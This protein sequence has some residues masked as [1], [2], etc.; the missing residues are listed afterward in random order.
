MLA[1][2]FSE[3]ISLGAVL[4]FIGILTSPE[5]MF[6][7]PIVRDFA[8][9]LGISSPEQLVLPI[10]I[11]FATAAIVAGAIRLLMLWVSQRLAFAMGTD[12][13]LQIY[14]RTLYQPYKVHVARNSSEVI[15]GITT[16]TWTV[17]EIIQS[18]LTVVSSVAI[19]VCLTIVLFAV[20]PLVMSLATT[21]LGVCY[22]LIAFACKRKVKFNGGVIAT[23]STQIVKA[24]QEGLGG[25]RDVLLS[26]SQEVYSETYRRADDRLRRAHGNN[27]FMS[28]GPRFA[29]EAI[30]MA[31]IAGLAYAMSLQ[32]GSVSTALPV[33]ATLALGA[34]RLLPIIQLLYNSW[35]SIAGAGKSLE[36]ALEFLDQP[37]SP[38]ISSFSVEPLEFRKCIDLVGV[39]FRYLEDGSWI[40]KDLDLK[41]LKGCRV[42]FVGSTGSGKSTLLDI[43]M[44]LLEPTKGALLV[45][46]IEINDSNRQAWQRCIAHVP[47]SI[48]LADTTIAENIAFG[49][50][51]EQIEMDRVRSAAEQARIA[52]FIENGPEG[53]N[54]LIGER[55]IR[56]SGGQ[57]QRIGIARAL[58]REA[59][60]LI[61]D[62]A[63]SSLDHSTEK[64]VME[65]IDGLDREL[66]ILLVAHRL[67]TMS[68]CDKI[69]ELDQGTIV[70]VYDYH[71][72]AKKS[73]SGAN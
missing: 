64:S 28:T 3:M 57:R 20:D 36:N 6:H 31:L 1:S 49:I 25:I 34:Q 9:R 16:K 44:G 37:V 62:E 15:S 56:L 66:T 59:T 46:G 39:N 63:T 65:A 71:T 47:Q 26:G 4:P 17:I 24:L 30:G 29:M 61:F 19:A 13:S 72:F 68:V 10:T 5:T 11:L 21:S 42:G 67:S 60:V 41:I 35:V 54:A 14:R 51:M 32:T 38:N 45:D 70:N 33:L 58:Y 12:L 7:Y 69:V 40:I 2:A 18:V 52:E 53:Y 55:G 23:E 43:V 48:F 22:G 8:C 73:L 50:P 27:R